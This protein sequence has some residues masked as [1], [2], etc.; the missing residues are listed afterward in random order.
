[1]ITAVAATVTPTGVVVAPP[2]LDREQWLTVRRTGVGGSEVAAV[3]GVPGD[4]ID[5]ETVPQPAPQGVELA[6]VEA[7]PSLFSR[8]PEAA[9]PAAADAAQ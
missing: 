4:Y 2:D 6:T 5:G 3:L 8:W 9:E 7:V 1:M